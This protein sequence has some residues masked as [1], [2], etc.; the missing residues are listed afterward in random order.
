MF[1]QDNF[2]I[3]AEKPLRKTDLI[4]VTEL[5]YEVGRISFLSNVFGAKKS[6]NSSKETHRNSWF[7][8]KNIY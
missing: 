4:A 6:R 5:L 2:T 3:Y 1:F 7:K 8:T